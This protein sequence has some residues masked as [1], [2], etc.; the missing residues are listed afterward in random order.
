[1]LDK[2]SYDLHQ[3]IVDLNTIF[4]P[5]LVILEGIEVMTTGGPMGPGELVRCDS[6]IASTDAVAADAAGVRL[7]PLFGR[8]V[9][10]SRVR[11]IRLAADQGL[12]VV[13]LPAERVSQIA[14][15]T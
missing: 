2:R 4:K 10:P 1:M 3:A 7:A 6:L 13:D 8:K 11:H 9:K 5:D 12:G 15:L 14:M